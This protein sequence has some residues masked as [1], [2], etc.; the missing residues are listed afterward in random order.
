MTSR[1][2]GGQWRYV[3][4]D[5][6]GSGS[7][8][9]QDFPSLTLSWFRIGENRNITGFCTT[10]ELFCFL[11]NSDRRYEHSQL[12]KVVAGRVDAQSLVRDTSD[13]A[14][15]SVHEQRNK[16]M[17]RSRSNTLT[18]GQSHLLKRE[19]STDHLPHYES[20]ENGD[21][22]L[23]SSGHGDSQQNEQS[24]PS[25][26]FV[27]GVP[28]SLKGDASRKRLS[29]LEP[30]DT[31]KLSSDLTV[32]ETLEFS[33]QM[34]QE[35][36]VSADEGKA[37]ARPLAELDV[38][39]LLT[40]MGFKGLAETKV[41]DLEK[42]QRRMVLFAT[43]AV[44]GKDVLLFDYPTSD[45]DVPSALALV[46]ALQRAAK[47]G[48]LVALT[49][50]SLTFREY[51]MLDKIQLLSS[52]GSI[53]FG[54]VSGA[55]NYFT[56]LKRTP[57]PG[58][59]ISDFLLDMVDDDL[60]PGGY[61]DAHLTF[62]ETQAQKSA[63]G[64]FH[65]LTK[66]SLPGNGE[67]VRNSGGRSGGGGDALEAPSWDRSYP[68]EQSLPREINARERS[69]SSIGGGSPAGEE[70]PVLSRGQ[71]LS[72]DAEGTQG[73]EAALLPRRAQGISA[74]MSPFGYQYIPSTNS[75]SETADLESLYESVMSAEWLPSA[76]LD[77][78]GHDETCTSMFLSSALARQFVLSL[79]RAFLVRWRG[80][81][82]IISSW[83][84]HCCLV[85]IA[86][87]LAFGTAWGDRQKVIFITVFPYIISLLLNLWSDKVLIY[88]HI[89]VFERDRGY[90]HQPWMSVIS[91][92]LADIV[93]YHTVPPLLTSCI[94]YYPLGLRRSW[95]AFAVF[96]STVLLICMVAACFSRALFFLLDAAT[97]RQAVPKRSDRDKHYIQSARASSFT[98]TVFSI[99]L[100]FTGTTLHLDSI[101]PLGRVV[102][103]S[104][105]F[106]WGT[107]ILYWNEWQSEDFAREHLT[108]SVPYIDVHMSISVLCAQLVLYVFIVGA[109]SSWVGRDG[110]NLN[111][112]C[113]K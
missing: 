69:P 83:G 49:M 72:A 60:W 106:F 44:A 55:M 26:I 102:Q 12:L 64:D 17:G 107:N 112:N 11:G 27:D 92:L 89:F 54:A 70:S 28:L 58:A 52:N 99:F 84:T 109:S 37:R 86:L 18:N 51:A 90:Y 108:S 29:Y 100:L 88:R 1:G 63:E 78:G 41:G 81:H 68:R 19:S 24:Q 47:G 48:R 59:S 46:T 50:T 34:R 87:L 4:S 23:S 101:G 56:S 39:R 16:I 32:L 6:P 20:I 38:L 15:T 57:S 110:G 76:A 80:L 36:K 22:A 25:G 10:G 73:T 9:N 82:T 53:Y 105:F 13:L 31:N 97:E 65:E 40:D 96:T 33:S 42:W 61:S 91:T 94:L 62:L 5:N 35:A 30:N 103:Y 93:Y 79:W 7:N 3:K 2:R 67:A 45:L 71:D 111:Y 85:T 77:G 95:S 43:E 21:N 113:R 98:A 74:G 8:T 104:S 14:E 75:V 66:T